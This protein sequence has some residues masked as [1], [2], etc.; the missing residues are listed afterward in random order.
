MLEIGNGGMTN[1]EYRTHFTLWS[2]AKAPLIIGCDLRSIKQED[3][4]ILKTTEIIALNQD[5]LGR[6]AMCLQSCS[7]FSYNFLHLSPQIWVTPLENNAYGV[8]LMNWN[9]F[10]LGKSTV[11]FSKLHLIQNAYKARDLWE[12]KDLGDFTDEMSVSSIKSHQAL[13]FKLTPI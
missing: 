10:S 6:Q 4:E 8:V 11:K 5:G 13:A 12:H 3:L 7:W 2:I 9:F 1:L